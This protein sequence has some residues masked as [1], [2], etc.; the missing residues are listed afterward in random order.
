MSETTLTVRGRVRVNGRLKDPDDK[1]RDEMTQE[2]EI[3]SHHDFLIVDDAEIHRMAEV[4]AKMEAELFANLAA[5][6][7]MRYTARTFPETPV[8]GETE[9]EMEVIGS[10][11]DIEIVGDEI[12][13]DCPIH[14]DKPSIA[15]YEVCPIDIYEE[16]DEG[17]KASAEL[18]MVNE[19][20]NRPL[21]CLE[22]P[23]YKIW[24]TGGGTSP[25]VA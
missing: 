6:G 17:C 12:L 19:P 9:T 15:L 13:K 4:L 10:H 20:K 8:K 23:K 5:A 11:G 21:S 14:S 2:I 16:M 25:E 18:F 22:C 24:N 7:G 3:T 1:W